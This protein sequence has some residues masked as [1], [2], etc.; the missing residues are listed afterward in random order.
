MAVDR[1]ETSGSARRRRAQGAKADKLQQALVD[2]DP[3]LARWANG[4]VFGEVWAGD[5][6]AH[7][8]RMLVAI[9]ALAALSRR[10]QLRNYLHGALQSGIG[11]DKLREVMK[12]MS[13]YAGFPVA[14]EAMLELDTV[15]AA[16]GRAR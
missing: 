6:L 5:A 7:D 9:A 15:I 2:L 11:A 1:S 14:I 10:N 16:N 3:D 4:F 13:V 8:E 12:M